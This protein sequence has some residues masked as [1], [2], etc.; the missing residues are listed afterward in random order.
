MERTKTK[1]LKL[2]GNRATTGGDD[3]SVTECNPQAVTGT[4][5]DKCGSK[6]LVRN[7]VSARCPV[8]GKYFFAPDAPER[9]E[10]E[11]AVPASGAALSL[12][13]EHKLGLMVK[14]DG[15]RWMEVLAPP[16][17]FIQEIA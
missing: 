9:S 15:W 10:A 1:A 13:N 6:V 14:R 2:R 5:C 12:W 7:Y 11:P 17:W 16:K 3:M 8:C 4:G